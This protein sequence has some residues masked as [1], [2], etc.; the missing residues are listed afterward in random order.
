MLGVYEEKTGFAMHDASDL[1]VRLY[2]AA[3]ELESLYAYSDW[4]L[5]QS[6]PQTASGTYLDY[7]GTLRGLSRRPGT[8]AAGAIRFVL[9]LAR[10]EAVEI[11]A[12]PV[13]TTAGL[14]RFVTTEPGVIAAGQ[15]QVEV[16]AEAEQA[17]TAGNVAAG[18]IVYLSLAPA[19]VASC[20]NPAAFAGGTEP[21]DDEAFRARILDT[22]QRLPNGANAAYYENRVLEHE[23]VSACTVIPRYQ[24]VGTVGVVVAGPAGPADE[25]LLQAIRDDLEAVREIAVEVSV[26]AP[27]TVSVPVTVQIWPRQGVTQE[28]AAAAVKT[29]IEQFFTGE[30]LSKP[31]YRAALGNCIYDTGVVENF[32]LQAPAQDVAITQT[33]LPVCGAVSVTEGA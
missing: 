15:T 20:V 18:T 17:G 32:V 33:Q 24:G 14:V 9:D 7:H 27:T 5:G 13:C 11:E 6:F 25:T 2:A 16:P 21:E 23:G 3:A 10:D 30:R 12:G 19:G 22:F 26:L 29:A 1:S 4:S 28:T 31:V 8:C